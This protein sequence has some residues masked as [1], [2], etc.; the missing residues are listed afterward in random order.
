VST[1]DLTTLSLSLTKMCN[2]LCPISVL[3]EKTLSRNWL[4]K[5]LRN[6]G[7]NEVLRVVDLI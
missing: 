1:S 4:H 5:Y 7:T 3:S 6:E 2:F